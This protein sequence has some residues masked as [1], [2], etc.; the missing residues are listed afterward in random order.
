MHNDASALRQITRIKMLRPTPSKILITSLEISELKQ[1]LANRPSDLPLV[2]GT[3]WFAI[4]S[5]QQSQNSRPSAWHK[6]VLRPGPRQAR[7]H[8][9]SQSIESSSVAV[10]SDASSELDEDALSEL[11]ADYQQEGSP[12][13]R[14][15]L[16]GNNDPP[17]QL[18]PSPRQ[19]G[20][21]S[22]APYH[23]PS[24]RD[25]VLPT[26]YRPPREPRLVAP[27]QFD[28]ARSLDPLAPSFV[29]RV[30]FG[31][32][33]DYNVEPRA[34][35]S[36]HSNSNHPCPRP[37]SSSIP[38]NQALTPP[39]LR[40]S[41][42]HHLR[43]STKRISVS[44]GVRRTR[45]QR[46]FHA[47]QRRPFDHE[48]FQPGHVVGRYPAVTQ[49]SGRPHQLPPPLSPSRDPYNAALSGHPD[50]RRSRMEH[51]DVQNLPRNSVRRNKN[52]ADTRTSSTASYSVPNLANL[53]PQ[54]PT[55][56]SRHS[57][58]T[59]NRGGS[60]DPLTRPSRRPSGA[61]ARSR[62]STG[63]PVS[64]P[65]AVT[66]QSFY[67][68]H[69]PLD[70]LS[71]GLR[72]LSA[73][74]AGRSSRQSSGGSNGM[75]P[76]QG[77][78]LGGSLFYS[79]DL[80]SEDHPSGSDHDQD[81]R[82]M[83]QINV[84]P[85]PIP[86]HPQRRQRL[87]R[88]IEHMEPAV[89]PSSSPEMTGMLAVMP[90]QILSSPPTISSMYSGSSPLPTMTS[91][92][93]RM[94]PV[95]SG[96][97][98]SLPISSMP[99]SSIPPEP[100]IP[101][102]APSSLLQ[103]PPTTPHSSRIPRSSLLP[104]KL[105]TRLTATPR[106]RIYDDDLPART[107][108]QT[109][110]DLMR[111]RRPLPSSMPVRPIT[112]SSGSGSSPE[113]SL[114]RQIHPATQPKA[115]FEPSTAELTTIPILS[116]LHSARQPRVTAPRRRHHHRRGHRSTSEDQEN[117]LDVAAIQGLEDEGVAWVRR[118]GEADNSSRNAV[119]LD[120]LHE[121]PPHEG[122]FERMMRE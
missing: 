88:R 92:P 89:V 91:S 33:D 72:R 58:L 2:T 49:S 23:L 121:T 77:N 27:N 84:V 1:R 64:R 14:Q 81:P 31:S 5:N 105:H 45:K 118:R 68:N 46:P 30:R 93:S 87:H 61:S 50:R 100:V 54:A 36:G 107:Q 44:R 99:M 7:G 18:R 95:T 113:K 78:L 19:R 122:R 120:V 71:A 112:F 75:R 104:D 26:E 42:R 11:H 10:V 94:S 86:Y 51:H 28:I 21:D 6:G 43:P 80:Y 17:L 24:F 32:A 114:H 85:E 62:H 96:P 4:H 115:I 22:N 55:I 25:S 15:T 35:P 47:Q 76:F 40:L 73:V 12:L 41:P 98:Y 13:L 9:L 38:D 69:S 117:E 101:S 74:S 90:S 53:P 108:P 63:L 60:I 106:F 119:A 39:A 16:D 83:P 3:D 103:A 102:D 37:F 97:T 109:P 79:E 110:A 29:P 116:P 8:I 20:G 82:M 57:S 70:E 48:A 65:V 66:P 34:P 59:W 67:L 56:H 111:R 52:A